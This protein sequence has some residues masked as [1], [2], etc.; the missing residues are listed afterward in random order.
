MSVTRVCDPQSRCTHE[1]ILASEITNVT[2][3]ACNLFCVGTPLD[4]QWAEWNKRG[5]SIKLYSH[6]RSRATFRRIALGEKGLDVV[7]EQYHYLSSMFDAATP[8]PANSI[9]EPII[10]PK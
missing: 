6:W 5:K 2:V 1:A 8:A 9:S 10:A 3:Q 7:A 4:Q